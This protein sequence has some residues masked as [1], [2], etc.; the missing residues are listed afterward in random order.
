MRN[1][2]EMYSLLIAQ[3]RLLEEDSKTTW[4]TPL[5]KMQTR[6]SVKAMDQKIDLCKKIT[7]AREE[8]PVVPSLR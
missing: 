5:K 2:C 4:F 1:T 6:Q 7:V 8:E 3:K